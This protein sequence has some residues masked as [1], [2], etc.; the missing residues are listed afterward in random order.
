MAILPVH[1]DDGAAYERMMGVW[2]RLAGDIFLAWLAPRD[3]LRWIDVGYGS[4]AFT[5]LLCARHAPAGVEGIDVSDAQLAFARSRP[6]A[7]LARFQQGD[8][9]ALPFA[10]SVFDAAVMALV[11]VFVPD[12]AHAVAEMA[13][14]AAP[15]GSV[16]AYVWDMPGGGFPLDTVWTAMRGM[17]LPHGMPPNIEAARLDALRDLWTGA[18]LRAVE[19]CTITVQR[20]FADFDD[21][22]ATCLLSPS[23]RPTVATL[24]PADAETLRERIR[25]RLTIDDAGRITC[26]AWA[27][28]VKGVKA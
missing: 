12:P 24:A 23:I 5:E 9:M 20:R 18:G 1:F 27:N 17:G 25:A 6:G 8:A 28:A 14:V 4:G 16:S 19:T 13:R 26:T 11:I 7:G 3:G 21:Y 10:D 15:G 22:W 2:S